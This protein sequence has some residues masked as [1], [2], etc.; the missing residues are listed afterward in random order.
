MEYQHP[1]G[2]W[3]DRWQP[4]WGGLLTALR[5]VAA[6][7]AVACRAMHQQG[8]PAGLLASGGL[9]SIRLF[10]CGSWYGCF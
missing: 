10:R 2:A 7:V 9:R 8:T 6:A 3:S 4:G 1:G 5:L